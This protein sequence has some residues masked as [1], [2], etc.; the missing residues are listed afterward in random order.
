MV[1]WEQQHLFHRGAGGFNKSFVICFETLKWKL[2]RKDNIYCLWSEYLELLIQPWSPR[3][4]FANV[5]CLP[6][7]EGIT[8]K[9]SLQNYFLK[10]QSQE[11][12]QL[13]GFKVKSKDIQMITA[14]MIFECSVIFKMLSPCPNL[15]CTIFVIQCQEL[16]QHS[17][18]L[19]L[20]TRSWRLGS[21]HIPSKIPISVSLITV[22]QCFLEIFR[23]KYSAGSCAKPKG[24]ILTSL[25]M[26]F[27]GDLSQFRFLSQSLSLLTSAISWWNYIPGLAETCCAPNG[28]FMQVL[29]RVGSYPNRTVDMAVYLQEDIYWY[30][31]KDRNQI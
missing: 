15:N 2:V 8:F 25:I 23:P 30:L 13:P 6:C 9:L 18:Q 17:F 31:D 14:W 11:K 7:N 24:E 20:R 28:K 5:N 10:F 4:L 29:L 12:L 19:S 26:T 21:L 22:Y 16:P 1:K 27:S 3:V